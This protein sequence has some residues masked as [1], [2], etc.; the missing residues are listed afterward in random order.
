MPM[1]AANANLSSLSLADIAAL[2]DEQKN[3]P[4]GLW[5]PA[6]SGHSK[7]QILRDGRWLH[8]GTA[9]NRE[10]MIRLFASILR[11]EEDGSYVLVTPAEKQV[12]DVEDAPFIA[13]EM[14]S[15]GTGN[16]RNIAFRINT[17]DLIILGPDHS[18][19]ARGTA[20]E[21]AHYLLVRGGLEARLTRSVYYE[22][23]EIA[24]AEKHDPLGIWGGG[25]FFGL[26]PATC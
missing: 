2:V 21:P 12:I 6:P 23:A 16:A 1:P 5:N 10:T 22:L 3:A 13:V 17:G 4:V 8:D 24:L 19:S 20:E 7:M 25:S 26:E 14:K 15:E 11:R 9:L 18:L